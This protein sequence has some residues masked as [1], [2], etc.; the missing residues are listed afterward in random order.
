MFAGNFLG[1]EFSLVMTCNTAEVAGTFTLVQ[2]DF[3]EN[4][5]D[6]VPIDSIRWYVAAATAGK[7]SYGKGPIRGQYI[8]I[9][10]N[11]GTTSVLSQS[12]TSMRFNG[13]G[14]TYAKD[15]WRD[16]NN[17]NVT[18]GGF[19]QTFG[20][21]QRN[22]VFADQSLAN[23]AGTVLN[24]LGNNWAGRTKLFL[25]ILGLTTK[26]CLFQ[27]QEAAGLGGQVERV[28][29]GDAATQIF[30]AEY[31]LART[32]Y[33]MTFTNSSGVGA[34]ISYTLIAQDY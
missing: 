27:L 23:G 10:M 30:E 1:Y 2:V 32:P 3:F 29:L 5:A 18:T 22:Q 33:L 34:T 11:N 4:Q 20:D 8:Q 31:V 21:M 19:K 17:G 7:T 26:Q 24:R 14:R 13:S 15:D 25:N 6:T 9:T 12:L 28:F 16:V